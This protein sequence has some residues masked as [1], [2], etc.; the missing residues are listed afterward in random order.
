MSYPALSRECLSSC[1][2]EASCVIPARPGQGEGWTV[3]MGVYGLFGGVKGG[4]DD[5]AKALSV[6]DQNCETAALNANKKHL[7]AGCATGF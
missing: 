6:L 1:C 5:C 7:A 4:A 2:T 3:C